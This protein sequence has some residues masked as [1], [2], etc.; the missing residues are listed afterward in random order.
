MLSQAISKRR[1]FLVL[2]DLAAIA[3]SYG[4]AFYL[5]P[6]FLILFTARTSFLVSSSV[7][8]PILF[9]IF[10]LYFPFKIFKPTQT[11]IDV[12][13]SVAIGTVI[14][15]ALSYADR[16]FIL[17]RTVFVYATFS[18][19]PFVF[20]I[21]LTYDFIFQFRLLDKKTLI[22]GTGPLAAEIAR[23]IRDTHHS[24]LEIVGLIYESKKVS[25]DS[26]NGV[27]VLGG[28][29]ELISLIDWYKAE[30]VIL[31]LDPNHEVSE[32]SLMS[33]L[34]KKGVTVT[35][36]IHLFESMQGE[37]PYQLLGSHYLLG[38]MAQVKTRPYLKLKRFI[39][40]LWGT[41]LLLAF[42]PV[43][44]VTF[45]IL[46]LTSGCKI[47]FIQA[48]IGKNGKP[49]QLI[50]FRS[51]TEI[52]KGKMV[53]TKFGRFIRRYRI[54]EIPQFINVLKGDMSLIGPR[55]EIPYFV[56]RSRKRIPFYDTVF[57]VKPGLT[58]WAQVKF[59]HATSVKDYNQK[60]R[61]NLYY[62]KN[63]SLTL[64]LVILLKTVRVVLIGNGK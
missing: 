46:A 39:D 5:R 30:L 43:F 49:F 61:Y 16:A 48:R 21:R 55:P 12:T 22:I 47:F 2:F 57:A 60:F 19:I 51:M 24:G 44:L 42:S 53:V 59:R 52:K 23:V 25:G 11:A 15:A 62:L 27:P 28:L 41:A 4:L 20:L 35:S 14:L 45:L 37:V 17:P 31:A 38:L 63:I 29:S 56:S 32:A 6:D 18:L 10:D 3:A 40:L 13:F 36:A 33:D 26:K 64:D 8:F 54:D 34:M 50:K 1:L 9:Y 58:G 7:V